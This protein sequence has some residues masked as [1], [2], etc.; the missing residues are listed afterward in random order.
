LDLIRPS[1]G[2]LYDFK[3]REVLYTVYIYIIY[4]FYERYI[5]GSKMTE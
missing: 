2:D 5:N 3:T 4:K 1:S